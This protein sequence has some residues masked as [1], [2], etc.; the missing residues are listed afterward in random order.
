[1]LTPSMSRWGFSIPSPVHHSRFPGSPT[2]PRSKR[3]L[4]GF[5]TLDATAPH[6]RS[7]RESVAASTLA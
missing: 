3:E 2:C 7:K 5:S 6:P 1:M 4:V